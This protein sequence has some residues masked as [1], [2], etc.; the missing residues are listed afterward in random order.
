MDISKIVM[1]CVCI[2]GSAKIG[3]LIGEVIIDINKKREEKK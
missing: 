1:V 3:S 2:I